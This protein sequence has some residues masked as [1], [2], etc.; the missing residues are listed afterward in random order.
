MEV[1]A[2]Q[3]EELN[4][5]ADAFIKKHIASKNFSITININTLINLIPYKYL[6][7]SI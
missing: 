7:H 5:F 6:H 1:P 2:I 3:V 4:G